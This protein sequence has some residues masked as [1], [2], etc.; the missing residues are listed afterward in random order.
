M[1]TQYLKF[2]AGGTKLMISVN[3]VHSIIEQPEIYKLSQVP[4]YI[5]G[6]INAN[7]EAIPLIDTSK[8]LNLHKPVTLVDRMKLL[9]TIPSTNDNDK[10]KPLAFITDDID[11]I[12]SIEQSKIQPLPVEKQQ[13]DDRLFL[14]TAELNGDL[15][16]L[17]NIDN[18]YKEN[19]DEIIEKHLNKIT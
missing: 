9:I 19:F 14:G 12:I 11:D 13:Y 18:F 8:R 16:M 10:F 3:N 15:F 7:N 4:D 17:L 6:V 5:L 1:S 2:T